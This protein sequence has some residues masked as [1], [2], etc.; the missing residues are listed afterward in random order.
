VHRAKILSSRGALESTVPELVARL[1]QFENLEVK[2]MKKHVWFT[3]IVMA[4]VGSAALHVK[5]QTTMGVRANVPF[6]FVVGDKTFPAGKITAHG[7]SASQAGS[8]SIRNLGSG[9][10]TYRIGQK[11]TAT[12]ASNEAKLVFHKYGDRYYLAQI[13]VPGYK[14]WEVEKSKSE[15]ALQ[16]EARLA[17]NTKPEVVTIVGE[18]Q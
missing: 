1:A 14:A 4:I 5:A 9:E 6:E 17:Q 12:D 11:L 18:L 10:Q 8:I 2:T 7:V 3:L 13:W 15:K 16:R